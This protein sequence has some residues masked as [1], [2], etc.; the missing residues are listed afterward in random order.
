[1]K[2]GLV[3]KEQ[4]KITIFNVNLKLSK[5]W[6]LWEGLLLFVDIPSKYPR[7]I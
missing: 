6:K 3:E 2:T 7:P 1:M 4:T 5:K